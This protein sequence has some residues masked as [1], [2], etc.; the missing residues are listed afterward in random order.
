M[1]ISAF[2]DSSGR[3][4]ADKGASLWKELEGLKVQAV[5][6]GVEE[7]KVDRYTNGA[8]VVLVRIELYCPEKRFAAF[9]RFTK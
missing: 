2:V 5:D 8:L 1:K 6:L 9:L 3:D 7:I 4:M